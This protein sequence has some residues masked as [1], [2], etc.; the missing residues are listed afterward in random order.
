M[1]YTRQRRRDTNGTN[2]PVNLAAAAIQYAGFVPDSIAGLYQINVTLPATFTPALAAAGSPLA[3]SLT[4]N[5]VSSPGGVII[6]VQ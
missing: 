5:S 6:Y 3:L 4:V 2:A 1:L